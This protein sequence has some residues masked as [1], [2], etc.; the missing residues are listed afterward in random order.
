MATVRVRSVK[1]ID[2]P[3]YVYDIT[4]SDN[5]NLFASSKIKDSPILVHNCLDEN[6]SDLVAFGTPH[7]GLDQIFQVYGNDHYERATFGKEDR[8]NSEL[9]RLDNPSFL[10]Y[11]ATDVISIWNMIH[12]QQERAAYLQIGDKSF[13]PYFRRVVLTQMSNTVH[14]L[15]HMKQYGAAVD[16]TYLKHL[17]GGDSPLLKLIGGFEKKMLKFEEVKTT[18]RELLSANSS[19]KSHGGLFGQESLIFSFRTAQHRI[20]LFFETMGLKPLDFTKEKQPKVDKAFIAHYRKDHPLVDE[21]GKLTKLKKL[22]STYIKGWW[23][24][25]L[26]DIDGRQDWRLRADYGFFQV[27]TGRLN[28]YDPNLQQVPS[29]GDE[30]NYIKRVF[31]SPLGTLHIKFDYSAHEVRCWAYVS[32]DEVLS[33]L[34]RVGQ[35]LR[36]KLRK[37]TTVEEAEAILKQLKR[38]GDI[39]ILNIKFFFDKW[40]EKSD[41]LRD[42]I[43]AVV[44][45]T[46]YQK[47]AKS[48]ARDIGK[49]VDFAKDLIQKLFSRF[50]KAGNWLE[51]SKGHAVTHYYT[52]SPFG[53]RRNLFGIMTGIRGAVA[54]LQRKAAN[55]PVQG[56]ASQAGITVAR[57]IALEVLDTAIAFDL[58]DEETD[59]DLIAQV[60]KAVHDANYTETPYRFIVPMIHIMQYVAT[61]GVTDYYKDELNVVFDVEPEIEIE[62]GVTEDKHYKWNWRN[63]NLRDIIDK[64]LADQVKLGDI[65]E[66]DLKRIRDEIEAPLLNRKFKRHLDKTYPIL[67]LPKYGLE[68]WTPIPKQ[69][70]E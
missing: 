60:L 61:Y 1:F 26:A 10:E 67:G 57:L 5:H 15:S 65:T 70:K 19:Q 25:L 3:D 52:Y 17:K 41:P 2:T 22:W 11:A 33:S 9:T 54:S 27:V 43:K 28:C 31:R 36:Q 21:F 68:L 63:D 7:G 69:D 4:V 56:L 46:I 35:K 40:V 59:A 16:K 32:G 24:K 66:K 49:P 44:F 12:M 64:S 50:A 23:N 34:F 62:V 6:R 42:A 18:N 47:S 39:H 48:L 20:K 53:F 55:S 51:W 14:V 58:M 45:G 8:A 13:R 37:A 38:D 29:R 30:S